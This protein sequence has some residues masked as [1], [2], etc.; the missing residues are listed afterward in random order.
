MAALAIVA[1]ILP[2]GAAEADDCSPGRDL[3][4]EGLGTW[5]EELARLAD[6]APDVLAPRSGILRRGAVST[7]AMCEGAEVPWGERYVDDRDGAL[8]WV[9][10]R[11]SL[12]FERT[13]PDGSND[14]LLW[15]GKGL[16]SLLSG[17]IRG[18][19]GAL[20]YQ[21]APEASWSQNAAF[22]LVDTGEDGRRSFAGGFY[23]GALD[24]PQ[25]FGSDS[26]F[27]ASPGQSY[28][29][30]E[31][32]GL[33]LGFSTE[34]RWW[35]PGIRH[36]VL[37]TNNAPGF[38]H[39]YLGTARPIDI[40][41]GDLEFE[42][43]VGRLTKSAYHVEPRAHP[44]FTGLA[45]TYRPRWVPGL[46]LGGGRTYIQSWDS[47]RD[48]WFLSVFEGLNKKSTGGDNP[49]DN[50]IFSAW[51]RWVMPDVEVYGEYAQDD[52]PTFNSFLRQP[53]RC[54]AWPLGLQKR[55]A[56][57]GRWWRVV[58][59][60]S[61][62]RSNLQGDRACT[63]YLHG[64][65]ADYT[66]EGQ[67]LGDWIGPG[68]DS[69]YL[70][71]DVFTRGGRIGGYFERVR[72][73]EEIYW[74]RRPTD[75]VKGHDAEVVLGLRQVLLLSR[76]EV[77]WHV[78]AGQRFNRDFLGDELVLRAGLTFTPVLGGRGASPDAE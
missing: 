10:P 77:S 22:E 25:R 55:I 4:V 67:L 46:Y 2:I 71:L 47:L 12:A 42:W 68:A 17:G 53:D 23:G 64:Q 59:E 69:Q 51:F 14:G 20:S 9:P 34:N 41:L 27:E 40:W 1:S 63:F 31:G 43:L 18:R 60:L 52:F 75:E 54:A 61:K 8:E 73:N 33:R 39:L 21:L 38:P 76:A 44:A 78:A 62:T 19:W 13:T 11:L 3:R 70:A 48:D 49:S 74:R 26:F 36:A 30:L 66:H 37:L 29:Q 15:Q 28:V 50:Q 32:Y 72:R 5:S 65:N 6:L 7:R 16:S 56:A 58:G 24:L 57:G 45:F 35:G